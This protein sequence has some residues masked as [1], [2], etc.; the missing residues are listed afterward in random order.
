MRLSS[1]RLLAKPEALSLTV[2]ETDQAIVPNRRDGIDGGLAQYPEHHW[3]FVLFT[4]DPA[5]LSAPARL[6]VLGLLLATCAAPPARG[7]GSKADY[8]RA[9]GLREATRDKVFKTSVRPHWL[10]GGQRFW[11]RNDLPDKVREFILVDAAKGERRPAFDHA[12]LAEALGKVLGKPQQASHPL[13]EQIVFAED[14]AIH[15]EVEGKAWRFDPATDEVKEAPLPKVEE[16]EQASERRGRRGRSQESPRASDSPDGKFTVVVRNHNVILR[17]KATSEQTPMSFEGSEVDGYE[18]RVYWSPDSSRFVALRTARGDHRVVQMI[19]S[20]PK[21]QLQPKLHGHDYL[22][23]GDKVPV[24]R[25][26][27][28]EVEGRKEIPIADDLAPNPW[29][30]DEFRWAPDSS[31]FTFLYNQRGHQVLRIVSV[32]AKTGAASPIVDECSKT[33]IDYSSKTYAH[34]LDKTHELI[35]MSERD[36]WN[37]LYLIDVESGKVKNQITRGPW[38]VLGVERVDD[39]ARQ[40]WFRAGASTPIRTRTTSTTRV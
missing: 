6:I 10:T 35:W 26:H 30:I 25:P 12:R 40:V 8:E 20:S 19:E 33:F 3:R 2:L 21:D 32:D 29:S 14:G 17:E 22:K 24:S 37:H 9:E 18:P 38:L 5:V 31:R 36:G 4:R 1:P 23:P 16:P 39:E 34:Y 15:F 28:F 27:L 11:Y 13:F 7:Q